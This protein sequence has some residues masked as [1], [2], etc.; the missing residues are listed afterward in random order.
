MICGMPLNGIRALLNG[1]G[2]RLASCSCSVGI[3]V[4][5]ARRANLHPWV[6]HIQ[7]ST[8]GLAAKRTSCRLLLRS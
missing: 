8:Q 3:T 7:T 6:V 4:E 5:L 1:K 2:N